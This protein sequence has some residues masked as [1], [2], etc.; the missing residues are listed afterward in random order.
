MPC[1]KYKKMFRY[2]VISKLYAVV[3]GLRKEN[4]YLKKTVSE[5]SHQQSEHNKILKVNLYTQTISLLFSQYNS[6][7]IMVP[8]WMLLSFTKFRMGLL[9]SLLQRLIAFE[10]VNL[11][12]CQQLMDKDE[13]TALL[14]EQSR[15]EE[16][17]TDIVSITR[18]CKV[19]LLQQT[20]RNQ[21]QNCE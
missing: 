19:H 10:C 14:S 2:K 16:E 15:K 21:E 4:A 6:S 1:Y 5:L 18:K 8:H 13:A 17:Q 3:R 11:E 12:D 9:C 7:V 20:A